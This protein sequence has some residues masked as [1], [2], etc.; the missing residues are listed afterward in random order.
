MPSKP[1]STEENPSLTLRE[2]NKVAGKIIDK[3]RRS[4]NLESIFQATTTELRRVLSCDRLVVYQ[5]N[6]DWSGQIVAESV[7][8]G[9]IS[10]LTES[11]E[12][13]VN[14]GEHIYKDRC[15]LRDWSK[16]D[17]GDIVRPD[18]YL[19]GNQGG[20]YAWGQKFT[21]VDN[22][23][24]QGF[25]DCYVKALEE[26]QAKAYLIVPIFQSKKL[27]GLL[28]AYQ[29]DDFRT[30]EDSEIELTLQ[31]ASQLGVALQQAEY[32]ERL[33]LQTEDLTNT[34]EQLQQAQQQIIQ[35]EKLAALG[36]LVAGI[37]HEINTPLG[38]IQASASNNQ[39]ALSAALVELPKLSEYLDSNERV[40][41]FQLVQQATATKPIFSPSE[42]RSLKRKL[43]NQLKKQELSNAR[44]TADLLIDIG[45]QTEIE[46][47][48]PLLRHSKANWI[49]DLAYNLIRL[50]GNNRTIVTSVDKASK[51]VFALKN[52]A[53]FDNSGEKQL[54]QIHDGLETVLE[55][56]HN[57]LKQNIEVIRHYGNLPT[58]YCYPDELIQVWTN[59]IH[60]GIQAM[61]GG[62]TLTL[63]TAVVNEGIEVA[64]AD[65]GSG[66]PE[67]I[68]NQIFEPFFTT[69]PPGEGSGL[70]LH[71][72]RKIVEKHQGTMTVDSQP[73]KTQ[74]KVWLPLCSVQ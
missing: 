15:T 51:V 27:W 30:W 72:S 62:G 19:Q 31:I 1:L 9:W 21:A 28:A 71:I 17:E 6:E 32:V 11:E 25:P 37:A 18:S 44:N 67:K 58:V 59:L 24:K 20:K 29:N 41:F 47:Y 63:S 49:L 22:I 64:I 35:Q 43:S 61:K 73:G 39:K 65:S 46:R 69:K 13:V 48:L 7:T 23:Y 34:L 16:G 45:I 3:I 14:K 68:K 5:F 42:K 53:R 8:E 70:G 56:Y 4:L 50:L 26:Y 54:A 12:Y 60:N 10:L 74:F 57:Q 66:I 55:I 38:A 52:Y 33:K 36:Q 2:K 40:L